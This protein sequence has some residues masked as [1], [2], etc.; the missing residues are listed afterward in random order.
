MRLSEL[1]SV[2]HRQPHC[3][4]SY[5]E[6]TDEVFYLDENGT[7]CALQ[8]SLKL[9]LPWASSDK[10]GCP[11]EYKTFTLRSFTKTTGTLSKKIKGYFLYYFLLK[12]PAYSSLLPELRYIQLLIIH[13]MIIIAS[14]N[15]FQISTMD[16]FY[17]QIVYTKRP[18]TPP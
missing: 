5:T 2:N 14:F 18:T 1:L 10:V 17:L 13:G 7:E 11:D 4:P 15:Y 16:L 8:K 9:F 3:I 6:K 12:Y